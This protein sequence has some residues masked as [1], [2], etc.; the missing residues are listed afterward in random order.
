V[1]NLDYNRS[2]PANTSTT[3]GFQ[4]NGTPSNPTPTCTSP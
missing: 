1:T 2:V 4:F 3:F